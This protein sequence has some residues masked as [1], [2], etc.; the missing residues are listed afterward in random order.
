[1]ALAI[2]LCSVTLSAYA[3]TWTDPS[4]GITWTYTVL[5]DGT[6]SLGGGTSSTPAIPTST[7]GS[8]VVPQYVN[9][10]LVTGLADH[11]F[12]RCW[13]MDSI[14]FIH[15]LSHIGDGI[16][17]NCSLLKSIKGCQYWDMSKK[18]YLD[19]IFA[20][21]ES[22]T[23]IEGLEAWDTSNVETI[24]DLFYFCKSLSLLVN[25]PTYDGFVNFQL[26][27]WNTSSLKRMA[28][29]FAYSG[30]IDFDANWNTSNLVEFDHV[31]QNCYNLR[32][33][34]IN[35]SSNLN[36]LESMDYAFENCSSL[37]S[38]FLPDRT[39][40]TKRFS[41][42]STFSGCTSLHDI[43]LS[44]FNFDTFGRGVTDFL[45]KTFVGCTNLREIRL[46]N[47][48]G[49]LDDYENSYECLDEEI[50]E[51][52]F[53]VAL[54]HQTFDGCI[55]LKSVVGMGLKDNNWQSRY[56]DFLHKSILYNPYDVNED[57]SVDIS[58]VVKIVNHILGQ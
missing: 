6:A 57:G 55:N 51:D 40:L 42:Y 16:F 10:L 37:E 32:V 20:G 8:I 38:I 45:Y 18:T 14:E 56:N 34:F 5:S 33:V 25:S 13:Y 41:L 28:L 47:C 36:N 11:A 17:Y 23:N 58:D 21:C 31:F 22:L 30:I 27:D 44:G 49:E 19:G 53:K 2:T 52:W 43:D 12:E 48:I 54:L 4:T 1:M 35:L 26:Q 46:P 50:S 29:T 39:G 9:G 3:E 24:G 7:T 15:P